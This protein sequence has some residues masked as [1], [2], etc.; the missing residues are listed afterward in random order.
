M[1]PSENIRELTSSLLGLHASIDKLIKTLQQN[2]HQLEDSRQI[3]DKLPLLDFYN[4][5]L[6]R[7]I[8][9]LKTHR[10]TDSGSDEEF[11]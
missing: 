9:I 3:M 2:A 6:Q 11:P 10:L 8:E 1:E 5:D 7:N 4:D